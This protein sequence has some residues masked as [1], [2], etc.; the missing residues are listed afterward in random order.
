MRKKI[1]HLAKL[2][3]QSEN[4][5]K[6][7]FIYY[8][9]QNPASGKMVRFRDYGRFSSFKTVSER[10]KY[11]ESVIAEINRKLLNGWRSYNII[12]AGCVVGYSAVNFSEFQLNNS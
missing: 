10:K 8:S 11:A 5:T 7:W 6:R 2:N 3:D 1:A 9:Y 4:L 12:N